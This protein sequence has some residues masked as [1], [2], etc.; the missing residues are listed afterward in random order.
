MLESYFFPSQQAWI[1][2]GRCGSVRLFTAT[3][4]GSRAVTRLN[5]R[6]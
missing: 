3:L 5:P 1:D 6:R 4:S 2:C